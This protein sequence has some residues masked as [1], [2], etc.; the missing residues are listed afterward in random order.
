MLPLLDERPDGLD[1]VVED[2]GVASMSSFCEVDLAPG[3]AGD[4]EQVVD[5]AGEVLDLPVDDVPAPFE[6]L[7]SGPER[8][9]TVTALLMA[10]SGFLS[11]WASIARNSSF[12]RSAS[13]RASSARFSGVMLV[14]VITDPKGTC[15]TSMRRLEPRSKSSLSPSARVKQTCMPRTVPPPTKSSRVNVPA[16]ASPA[17]SPS[18]RSEANTSS[19][20]RP[21]G[22]LPQSS[23]AA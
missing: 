20:L 16:A 13:L 15:S 5:E 6:V 3:D 4:V 17:P 23:W 11:S 19:N 22:L 7:L 10:A 21:T 14:S 18:G 12:R 2:G 9:A 1:G 8:V